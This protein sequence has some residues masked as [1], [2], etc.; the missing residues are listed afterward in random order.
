MPYDY[1]VCVSEL[2]YALLVCYAISGTAIQYA[3]RLRYA[4]C[5]TE[6]Q[7]MGA[8]VH[9]SISIWPTHALCGVRVLRA[10]AGLEPRAHARYPPTPAYA[11]SGTHIAC[12]ATITRCRARCYTVP[13]TDD[14]H[15]ANALRMSG[16][17]QY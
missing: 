10:P 8:V 12:G 16:T 15:C 4:V 17:P 13:G 5:S 9:Q 3:L 11:M 6:R 7:R 2:A 1:A 14:V